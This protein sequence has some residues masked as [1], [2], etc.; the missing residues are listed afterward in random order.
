MFGIDKALFCDLVY[1]VLFKAGRRTYAPVAYFSV[2]P[3]LFLSFA[4]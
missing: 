3:I 2:R 4:Q 1:I